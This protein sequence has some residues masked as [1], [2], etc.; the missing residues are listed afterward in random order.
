MCEVRCKTGLSIGRLAVA[1]G[2]PRSTTGRWVQGSVSVRPRRT[3]R[4]PVSG[5]SVLRE[6][7]RVL[8]LE[9]RE[10]MRGYRVIRAHLLRRYA[11]R[12]SRKTV[13]RVMRE[14]GLTQPKMRRKPLRP[15]RVE[16]MRPSHPDQAWQIDM[17]SFQ[18]S[19]LRPV[20]LVTIVVRRPRV[21]LDT[22]LTYSR[23]ERRVTM[24]KVTRGSVGAERARA[25]GAP[26]DPSTTSRGR[27]SVQKK[28]AAVLRMMRGESL[29]IVSRDLGVTAGRLSE[30]RD[31]FH[32]G[33][34][35]ALRARPSDDRDEKVKDLQA[36]VGELTMDNELLQQKIERLEARRPLMHRRSQ[37]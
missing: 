22:P 32:A 12:V 20:Y 36:T 1:F 5:C 17:T 10:R 18:R 25:S 19:D 28:T 27:F 24:G 7:I 14:L 11:I 26:T 30:W 31:Q 3:R 16:R 29:D 6:R 9:P 34:Q 15:K 4:R 2:M 23:S 21:F 8:C 35:A 13:N 37:K 33:A